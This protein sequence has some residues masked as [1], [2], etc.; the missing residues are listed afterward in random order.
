MSGSKHEQNGTSDSQPDDYMR[1]RPNKTN[2]Q[3]F[4]DGLYNPK[5][6]YILGRS[7]KAWGKIINL[8]INWYRC[9]N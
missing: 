7:G 5:K 4:K 3:S 6:G 2:W 8:I 9:G 1:K